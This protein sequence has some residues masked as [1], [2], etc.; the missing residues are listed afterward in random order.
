MEDIPNTTKHLQE[1]FDELQSA[2]SGNITLHLASENMLDKLFEERLEQND[3]LPLGENGNLLL[4]ETSYF[5][6]PIGLQNILLRIK[7]KG[8]HPVLAHP[9]RYLY[10]D[11][12]YYEKLKSMGVKFQL[13][14]FSVYGL[15]GKEVQKNA[16]KLQKAGMYEYSGTDLHGLE[17]L[18]A[19]LQR[20]IPHCNNRTLPISD[21]AKN[22]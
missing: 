6:P 21:C 22:K 16:Y 15:Y 13:N 20:K 4:V 11:V 12:K 7:T 18:K 9:E 5:S 1:R 19:M 10:M 17:T 3:M 8:Y 2:Y 14:L